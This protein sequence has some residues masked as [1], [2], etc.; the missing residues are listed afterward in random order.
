MPKES[1]N[2]KLKLYNAITDAKESAIS[3]FNDIFN[4][5]NS[6][7]V[8]ID[9]AYGEINSSYIKDLKPSGDKIIITKGDGAT[10]EID[11]AVTKPASKTNLGI[12]QIGD[13]IFVDTAGVI[14]LKKDG[15][16]GAL[17]YEAAEK[18]NLVSVTIPST[19]WNQDDNSAY[20]NYIDI[21]A[22]GITTSDCVALV[23]APSSNAV[24]KKCYF[25]ATEA[26]DGKIRIRVRNIPTENINTF[27]YIIREDILMGFGQTPIGGAILP[28]ATTTEIGGVIVGDGL[29]VSDKGVMSVK[30]G[31]TKIDKLTS[32]PVGSIYQTVSET[33]P[34]ALFGGSWERIAQNKVLMNASDTHPAGTTVE[35]GLPN[36]TGSFQTR[37]TPVTRYSAILVGSSGAFGEYV[38]HG[39][40]KKDA[41]IFSSIHEFGD[42]I[43]N[44]DIQYFDASGSNSIYGSSDTVQ[45]PAYYVYIWKRIS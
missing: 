6:N 23:I 44:N 33:S 27:Y 15:V 22:T 4:Y 21:E 25:A 1:T 41:P 38:V 20:P 13:N 43:L 40:P 2:L 24:A 5:S 10:S 30:G 8:K 29:E 12:V 26:L 37:A 35:A 45:P 42:P 28:P 9:N 14:S 19:G 17:G 32:Y 3:W 34:A 36:I 18:I 7:W 16:D 39:G 11:G 31:E